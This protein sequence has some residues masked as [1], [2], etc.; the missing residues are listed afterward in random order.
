MLSGFQLAR[1]PFIGVWLDSV[2]QS[3]DLLS[4]I[5]TGLGYHFYFG[6][7]SLLILVGVAMDTVAQIEAQLVMRNYEGF[8]FNPLNF[9]LFW[10]FVQNAIEPGA[11]SF[12]T[13]VEKKIKA[14]SNFNSHYGYPKKDCGINGHNLLGSRLGVIS[15]KGCS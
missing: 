12:L 10:E 15:N 4:W 5:P 13:Q 6:G 8:C 11:R 7:T 1:L 3:S 9:G 2:A 14:S